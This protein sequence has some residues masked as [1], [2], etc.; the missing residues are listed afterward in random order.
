MPPNPTR[1]MSPLSLP[2]PGGMRLLYLA[3]VLSTSA[4]MTARLWII[5]RVD[6]PT[7]L[8]QL[9]LVLF[10][11][12]S[13]WVASSFWLVCCGAWVRWFAPLR[14]SSLRPVAPQRD[15]NAA[16]VA[17]VMPVYNEDIGRCA[18]G[19]Q[20]IRESVQGCGGGSHFAFFLLSDSTDPACCRAEERAW[21]QLRGAAPAGAPVYY[22]H[23]DGNAGRKSGNIAEFCRNWGTDYTYMVVLDADSL[24]TGETLRE[25]TGLME[26]NPRAALIQVAPRLVGR[27]TMFARI[28]QFASNVYGPVAAAGLAALSGPDG[29]YWGH[30]AILRVCAF[31]EHCGLPELPG[32]APLGGEILSHDFVEA[33]LLRRAGWEV[34]MASQLEGSYEEVPPTVVDYLKRDR[35]WC[36]GNLQHIRLIF[37][38]G[39]RFSSRLHLASGAMAYLAS[40]LWL[41]LLIVALTDATRQ[42]SAASAVTYIG[43]YPVLPWQISHTLAFLSLLGLSMGM[44]FGQK[45]IGLI[46]T[47]RDPRGASAYGG[48]LRL[49]L[50]VALETGYSALLA[51]VFMLTHSWF[52]LQI[53]LGWSAGWG[54]QQRKERKLALG[55]AAS[56]F[57]PHTALAGTSA[58]VVYHFVPGALYWFLPLILGLA[59]AIPL[60]T[61]TSSTRLGL[62]TRKRGLFLIPSET[63]GLAVLDR[64]RELL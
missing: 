4:A 36:Q 31:I 14:G 59:L 8:E 41:T 21:L 15:A 27:H 40:P 7:G 46:D 12:L 26:A 44:L 56:V 43:A 20:A 30:N 34:W 52:V 47:L 25:L 22:R 42:V 3:L 57:A 48:R 19:I 61:L 11:V 1:L 60:A 54:G 55:S 18:A 2:R 64:T 58:M 16:R 24:M 33:A 28:Q 10:A 53:L 49:G 35:R 62:A 29:N 37:A 5:L 9:L 38:R 51:P 50:S 23:R 32:R 45:L 13:T 39:F 6:G 63:Q 17:V